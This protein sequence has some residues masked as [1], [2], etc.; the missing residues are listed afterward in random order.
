MRLD[1]AGQMLRPK[2]LRTGGTIG[3]VAPSSP[4][5]RESLS[6]AAEFLKR[7][8][9]QVR[10]GE[11]VSE[12]Y[13]YLAGTDQ[14]R[15]SDVNGMFADHGIDAIFIARGGYGSARLLEL[16]DYRTIAKNPKVFVGYSD[17]TA[18]QLALWAR[19]RLVSFYGP[20]ATIDLSRSSAD[21]NFSRLLEMIEA[22]PNTELIPKPWPRSVRTISHGR[23]RGPLVGGCLSVLT[24]LVGARHFPE[25]KGA[26]LFL[27][28]VDE[29]PY[30]VDRLLTQLDLAGVLPS[31]AGV[32]LGHFTRCKG[33]GRKPSLPLDEVLI[34]RFA[35]RGYPVVAGLPFGHIARKITV[36]QGISV[37]IDTQRQSI[38]LL[39]PP[40]LD[41]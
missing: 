11:H 20:L 12:S 18:L 14:Q 7:R 27:E 26:V 6:R 33:R 16:I 25:L 21:Y 31:L 1:R 13:G 3:L 28:D 36:P 30:R 38:E 17:A 29:Q 22:R 41:Q 23:T 39:E 2:P 40:C 35:G 37:S 24:S 5:E 32:L 15:A 8:G 9:Y 19:I 34:E 4:V 10:L